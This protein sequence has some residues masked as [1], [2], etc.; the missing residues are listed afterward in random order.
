MKYSYFL[1]K[2]CTKNTWTP[3]T[4]S[5]YNILYSCLFFMTTIFVL[6]LSIPFKRSQEWEKNYTKKKRK[7]L[8]KREKGKERKV[9]EVAGRRRATDEPR[10]GWRS[11]FS[12]EFWARLRHYQIM[13]L[14]TARPARSLLSLTP[15]PLLLS[16]LY[17]PRYSS[18]PMPSSS[19]Q[20]PS[21]YLVNLL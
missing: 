17:P 14:V 5:E 9:E 1:F 18:S 2:A 3:T 21:P 10:V 7:K 19:S 15:L 12:R 4:Y 13:A 8:R 20:L 16:Q 6:T 11:N